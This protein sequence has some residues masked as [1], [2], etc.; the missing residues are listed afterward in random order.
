MNQKLKI[1]LFSCLI[2]AVVCSVRPGVAANFPVDKLNSGLLSNS[3]AVVES[4]PD[5]SVL[6]LVGNVMES[7]MTTIRLFF[8]NSPGTGN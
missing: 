6:D 8:P 7:I 2:P 5:S 1:A 3:P 4:L